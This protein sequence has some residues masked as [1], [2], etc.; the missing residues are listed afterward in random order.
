[1]QTGVDYFPSTI[2]L[3]IY[4]MHFTIVSWF[5]PLEKCGAVFWKNSNTSTSFS[6]PEALVQAKD[7]GADNGYHWQTDQWIATLARLD[8]NRITDKLSP[9]N[10]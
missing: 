6:L 4:S 9:I 7:L 1:M 5:I 10:F 2:K 3:V 8:D